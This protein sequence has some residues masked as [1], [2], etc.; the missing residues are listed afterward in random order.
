MASKAG[1]ESKLTQREFETK[2]GI[3]QRITREMR[4][5]EHLCIVGTDPEFIA[6]WNKHRVSGRVSAPMV[7][8]VDRELERVK[9]VNGV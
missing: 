2:F 4:I 7:Q 3:T 1:T 5:K 9:R 6:M 8:F